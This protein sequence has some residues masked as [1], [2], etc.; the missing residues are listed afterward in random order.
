[1]D[2]EENNMQSFSMYDVTI[3]FQ[4]AFNAIFMVFQPIHQYAKVTK[5]KSEEQQIES[6][7]LCGGILR[8]CNVF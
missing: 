3:L 6:E 4:T 7:R 1:M 5:P 2:T 8:W